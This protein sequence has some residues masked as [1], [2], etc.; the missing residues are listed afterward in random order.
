MSEV[1]QNDWIA[2]LDATFKV[3]GYESD[4]TLD[5]EETHTAQSAVKSF[6]FADLVIAWEAYK[7]GSCKMTNSD[8]TLNAVFT[9]IKDN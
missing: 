8:G 5:L 3:E 6:G 1:N 4:G 2:F 9:L 7:N